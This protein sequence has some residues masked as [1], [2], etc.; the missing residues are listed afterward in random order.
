M[1]LLLLSD[2]AY[3]DLSFQLGLEA[4]AQLDLIVDIQQSGINVEKSKHT[5]PGPISSD[6]LV[7]TVTQSIFS[8][9]G[10]IKEPIDT[11]ETFKT[12]NCPDNVSEN[13]AMYVSDENYVKIDDP[14]L[15]PAYEDNKI[16][17]IAY[18]TGFKNIEVVQNGVYNTK[19][20]A[21]DAA[22]DL[23]DSDIYIGTELT[24]IGLPMK[25]IEYGD[26]AFTPGED[27]DELIEIED[28]LFFKLAKMAHLENITVNE[29]AAK[30]LE[31]SIQLQDPDLSSVGYKGQ[32]DNDSSMMYAPFGVLDDHNEETKE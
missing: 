20:E 18:D 7:E 32:I 31:E 9:I 11:P 16:W 28:D 25:N 30:I 23:C 22:L 17:V 3:D 13:C 8:S 24:V 29:L 1:K 26:T 21:E 19:K 2:S 14:E 15:S 27:E 5:A 6:A 10:Y 4:R 12:E